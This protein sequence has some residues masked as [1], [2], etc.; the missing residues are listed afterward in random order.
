MTYIVSFCGLD[1]F[2]Y[3][4]DDSC[5]WLQSTRHL[6]SVTNGLANALVRP[7]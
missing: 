5:L 7:T 3:C 2:A 1:C 6:G 4:F